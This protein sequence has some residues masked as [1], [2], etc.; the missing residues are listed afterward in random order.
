MFAVVVF[1]SKMLLVPIMQVFTSTSNNNNNNNNNTST[2][3]TSTNKNLFDI[4]TIL[5]SSSSSSSIYN[6]KN[7]LLY[8]FL[9]SF[10]Y[11]LLSVLVMFTI[12][13]IY[14]SVSSS[15]DAMFY[16]TILI[17][18]FIYS[19]IA[20]IKSYK[21][22]YTEL[23][24]LNMRIV[25]VNI[26]YNN[27]NNNNNSILNQYN[28][29]LDNL[30]QRTSQD[31]DELTQLLSKLY[32]NINILPLIILFYTIYLFYLCGYIAP[33]L[34]YIYMIIGVTISSIYSKKI[35]NLVYLQELF[36]GNFRK[37][38][39][40]LFTNIDKIIL[41]K[42]IKYEINKII[43]KFQD[44][45]NNKKNLIYNRLLLS[46]V[47]NWFNYVGSIVSYIVVGI[48]LFLVKKSKNYSEST[49]SGKL[50]N[51]S[52]SSLYLISAFSTVLQSIDYIVTCQGLAQR[53]MEVH[54]N[55]ILAA[56]QSNNL[57]ISP[58]IKNQQNNSNIAVKIINVTVFSPRQISLIN[59]LNITITH[60]MRLL[61]TGRSGCGKSTL[62]K[63]LAENLTNHQHVVFN[64]AQE[65]VYFCS[66]SPYLFTGSLTENVVYQ[67]EK[68]NVVVDIYSLLAQVK[69]NHIIPNNSN[70][71][72]NNNN[73][74]NNSLNDNVNSP[75]LSEED[76]PSTTTTTTTDGV[77]DWHNILSSGEKQKIAIARILYNQPKI[78]FVDECT[79]SMDEE[80]EDLIYNILTQQIPTIISVGHRTT[81][82][83]FH[84]HELHINNNGT[85]NICKL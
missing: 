22:Y 68:K 74:N 21:T 14:E 29:S 43:Y 70:S 66:Q 45:V 42:S 27:N 62:L 41:L 48:S 60:G 55:N 77:F 35:I 40:N 78:L 4:I 49:I 73:N 18:L 12:S 83:K 3:N 17:S 15:N 7:Y 64:C 57:F 5:I 44:L 19:F 82:K 2:N 23:L 38:Q 85:Y 81:I 65:H 56:D 79:S 72:N 20:L 33:L 11:E 9:L 76:G 10:S 34:C 71:N 25:L 51:G 37:W 59:N 31:I 52:Y 24:A 69:F 47:V 67:Q 26:L 8:I 63:F 84:T 54:N 30:D 28:K 80:E 6:I 53:V 61:I 39:V 46:I 32:E 75:L 36:E 58:S 50:A 16:R 13:S 1:D